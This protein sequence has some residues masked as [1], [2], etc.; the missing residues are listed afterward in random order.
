[1]AA[2]RTFLASARVSTSVGLEVPAGKDSA[3]RSPAAIASGSSRNWSA[4]PSPVST[5]SSPIASSAR[6]A[7]V[8]PTSSAGRRCTTP[9]TRRQSEVCSASG[10]APSRGTR[11]QN[12]HRPHSTSRAG[13]T[14]STNDAATTMPIAQ[15]SPRPRVLGVSDSSSVSSPSTTVVAL[16]STGS[17]VRRSARVIASWREA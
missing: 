17:T 2:R 16:A 12:T 1:M 5:R 6:T 8:V 4:R 9:P 7:V 13:S 11:G 10:V 14:T 15:A 3:R